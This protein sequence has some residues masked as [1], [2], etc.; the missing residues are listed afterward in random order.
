MRLG[1]HAIDYVSLRL[2]MH[3]TG[4][5]LLSLN[6]AKRDLHVLDV[7]H[8][9]VLA[10]GSQKLEMRRLFEIRNRLRWVIVEIFE[11]RETR[12]ACT[13]C[14]S[15]DCSSTR[16]SMSGKAGI[17]WNQEPLKMRNCWGSRVG[18]SLDSGKMRKR[19]KWGI[20]IKK[21]AIA[22]DGI[23]LKIYNLWKSQIIEHL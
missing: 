2:Y 3:G 12:S 7:Y 10:P 5:I 15:R 18:K 6:Y 9:I 17:L 22:G 19:C 1:S 13:G 4:L 16:F 14:V 8:A 20:I 21:P 11:L 23:S